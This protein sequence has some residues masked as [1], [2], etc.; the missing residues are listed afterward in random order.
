MAIPNW[1]WALVKPGGYL[2]IVVPD[3]D[4]Y[5]QGMWPSRFNTDHKATFNLG[6][7]K[8][9]S[10]VS[11]DIEALVQAL[12]RAE[13]IEARLG[14]VRNFGSRNRPSVMQR[15]RRPAS[16]RPSRATITRNRA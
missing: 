14:T 4:L 6:E 13:I 11:Y 5:E 7:S 16:R 10:P 15:D 8:S 3:E 12:P 1:W 2:V 9:W